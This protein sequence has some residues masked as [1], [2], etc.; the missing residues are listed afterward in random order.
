MTCRAADLAERVRGAAADPPVGVADRLQQVLDRALVAD[1]V[2]HLDRRA[3]RALGLV[4]QHLDQVADGVRVLA[5]AQ[6]LDRGVLD[7][8]VGVAQQRR[9]HRGI[10]L[11]AAVGDGAQRRRAHQLVRVLERALQRGAHLG[12]V[13]AGEQGDDVRARDGVLAVDARDQFVHGVRVHQ[14]AR[15]PEQGGLLVRVLVVGGVQEVA[16]VEA[17]LL[18]GDDVEH[19]GLGDGRVLQQLEQQARANS[20]ATRRA[21]RRRRRP[22][23]GSPPPAPW[24]AAGNDLLSIERRQHLDERDRLALVRGRERVD[25]RLDGVLAEALQP[26]QRRLRLRAGR[27]ATFP[28]LRDEAIRPVAS[29]NSHPTPAFI[30]G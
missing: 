17:V 4:L 5:A 9:D 24:R 30:A 2:Q 25:D 6:E 18:R 8:D 20:C 7:V 27:V 11:A 26:G 12:R 16:Q 28:Y 29:E 15:D 1:D 10:H 3:A 13:E 19:R 21:P 14:L 22:R 23:A